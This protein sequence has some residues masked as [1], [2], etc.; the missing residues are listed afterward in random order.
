MLAWHQFLISI[1][2]NVWLS[3]TAREKYKESSNSRFRRRKGSIF[4]SRSCAKTVMDQLS[5]QQMTSGELAAYL[6]IRCI[7]D[8]F[9]SQAVSHLRTQFKIDL[10]LFIGDETICNRSLCF[11]VKFDAGM[12]SDPIAL[13]LLLIHL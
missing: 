11:C 6:K 13:W 5:P 9:V 12:F 2:H 1:K 4:M 7:S 3:L 10:G 8:N